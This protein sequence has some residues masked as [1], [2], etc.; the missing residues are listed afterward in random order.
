MIAH[1]FVDEIIPDWQLQ[2]DETHRITIRSTIVYLVP[3]SQAQFTKALAS[4]EARQTAFSAEL[5]QLAARKGT[6]RVIDSETA[7]AARQ[8]LSK[9]HGEN[10][11]D[12]FIYD[13]ERAIVPE[14]GAAVRRINN[15]GVKTSPD[16]AG[17][18]VS[19]APA[20]SF[21]S[22]ADLARFEQKRGS[23][24]SPT[25]RL[26]MIIS[27]EGPREQVELSVDD[28]RAAMLFCGPV[29]SF[30]EIAGVPDHHA[31]PA[32]RLPLTAP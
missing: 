27:L 11:L 15:R 23:T 24:W 13:T 25:V 1:N 9:K 2:L 17:A 18:A 22:A 29:T 5:T 28:I 14:I 6:L 26:E 4:L 7:I 32:M 19:I 8:S 16:R 3:V 21:R 30:T 10:F 12:K 20:R 31:E